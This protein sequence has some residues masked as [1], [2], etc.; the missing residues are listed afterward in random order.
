[1]LQI[2]YKL[3]KRILSFRSCRKAVKRVIVFDKLDKSFLLF[4][5]LEIEI[6]VKF[7]VHMLFEIFSFG[8]LLVS[9]FCHYFWICCHESFPLG[10]TFPVIIDIVS[11]E[12]CLTEEFLLGKRFG[13]FRFL[14]G[15]FSHFQ[16]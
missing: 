15:R 1:M 3:R 2:A 6:S 13:L 4:L 11:E 14:F 8:L 16:N 5:I 9:L 10:I 7:P 12:L